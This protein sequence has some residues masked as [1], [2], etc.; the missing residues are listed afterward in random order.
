M[1]DKYTLGDAW[2]ARI[3]GNMLALE[4]GVVDKWSRGR[5]V[6]VGD[7]VH[8]VSQNIALPPVDDNTAAHATD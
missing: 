3:A 2:K 5:A 4:E 8:K 7:A 6:L 1:C